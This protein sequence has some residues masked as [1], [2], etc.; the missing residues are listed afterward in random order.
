MEKY[1]SAHFCTVLYGLAPVPSIP[2]QDFEDPFLVRKGGNDDLY[3]ILE[4]LERAGVYFIS[5]FDIRHGQSNNP[6]A[7]QVDDEYSIAYGFQINEAALEKHVKSLDLMRAPPAVWRYRKSCATANSQEE[8]QRSKMKTS[9]YLFIQWDLPWPV[10]SYKVA[11]RL[12]DP[13]LIFTSKGMMMLKAGDLAKQLKEAREMG[14]KSSWTAS[15]FCAKM[16][17]EVPG[18]VT[19]RSPR[20]GADLSSLALLL[21]DGASK[22]SAS[23]STTTGTSSDSV[24]ALC[25]ASRE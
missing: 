14:L 7:Q 10:L 19:R 22:D 17:K 4:G 24:R 8:S 23:A 15:Q 6:G 21:S 25:L 12:P 16:F 2:I 13:R 3:R 11:L 18:R 5:M 20:S 9:L 1:N